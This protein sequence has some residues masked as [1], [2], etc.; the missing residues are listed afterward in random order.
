[1][2]TA[3][4]VARDS[5]Q[6]PTWLRK[7]VIAAG[8]VILV[9]I[10]PVALIALWLGPVAAL[11][12]PFG[13]MGGVFA[14]R[15]EN[16]T[17]AWALFPLLAIGGA[18]SAYTAGTWSWVVVLAVLG[19]IIGF[20]SSAGRAVAV[21]EVCIIVVSG[22]SYREPRD[23][24]LYTAFLAIGY[25]A[26]MLI[27]RLTGAAKLTERK[28]FTYVSG[29]RAMILCAGIMGLAGVIGVVLTSQFG[30]TK[31]YWLPMV[32][33]ILLEFYITDPQGGARMI[34]GRVVGTVLGIALL[35]PVLSQL[36]LVGQVVAFVALIA[37]GIATSDARYWL[38]TA[39]IA[40]A[41]VLI[42]S[43]GADP[44]V[45][46]NQRFWSTFIAFVLVGLIAWGMRWVRVGEKVTVPSREVV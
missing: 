3:D 30:W 26:G 35:I 41:V 40:A 18:L 38:S 7:F 19:A 25:L 45:V 13:L 2:S 36:P 17:T 28:P 15:G 31:A 27:G 8:I 22:D 12:F 20:L 46:G 29:P 21:I 16:Q 37:A 34:I 4:I 43:I 10:V 11:A 1:M 9:G 23:L 24:L 14:S 33:L 39:Y 5:Y 32:F 44:K 6:G 42:T